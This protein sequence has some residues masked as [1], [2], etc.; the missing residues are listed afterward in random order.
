[1]RDRR[2]STVPDE[3]YLVFILGVLLLVL[4]GAVLVHIASPS[5]QSS[6]QRNSQEYVP[7]RP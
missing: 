5:T 2:K 6:Q 1:M 7:P 3:V 4:A